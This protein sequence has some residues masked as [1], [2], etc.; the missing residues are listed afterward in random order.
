MEVRFQLKYAVE[1]DFEVFPALGPYGLAK[2]PGLKKGSTIKYSTARGV[3][4]THSEV[5]KASPDSG[6]GLVFMGE[7][8]RYMATMNPME[9]IWFNKFMN[10]LDIRMA[11]I[12][13]QDRAFLLEIMHI[14]MNK[15]EADWQEERGEDMDINEIGAALFSTVTFCSSMRGY[16][17]YMWTDL[18]ALRAELVNIE[19]TRDYRGMGWT[20][21]RKFKADEGQWNRPSRHPY[22]RHH[23]LGVTKFALGSKDGREDGDLGK[24][25]GLCLCENAN[26]AEGVVL[27]ESWR[28]GRRHQFNVSMAGGESESSEDVKR[29]GKAVANDWRVEFDTLK[30]FGANL[31]T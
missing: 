18:A 6:L 22:C 29:G 11:D 31:E 28:K 16:E 12:T 7:R 17:T 10:G 30:D 24:N 27:T 26:G 9:G 2:E 23:I 21:V 1:L 15:Y 14:L 3:H 19:L 4:S 8:K 5:W 20:V 25:D 13:K